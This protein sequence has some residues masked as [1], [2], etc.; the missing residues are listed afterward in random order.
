MKKII[1]DS[2]EF[3]TKDE[4]HKVL[5]KKMNLPDYYGNNLDALWDCITGYIPLPMTVEWLNFNQSKA[6][7]GEYA[8]MVLEVFE[9]AEQELD[10][11]KIIIN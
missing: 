4:L 3:L 1:L 8:D 6:N 7:L 5:K 10:D 11:F 9:D 2:K